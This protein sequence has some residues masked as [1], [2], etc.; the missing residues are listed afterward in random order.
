[1]RP[2][3]NLD[4]LL[5]VELRPRNMPGDVVPE[6][7]RKVRGSNNPLSYET[8]KVFLDHPSARVGIVTGVEFPPHLPHGEI[9][10]LIG[11]VVLGRALGKLG[12]ATS[13]LVEASIVPVIEALI[14]TLDA[15]R[16]YAVDVSPWST[17]D[18]EDCADASDIGVAIEKIG[19]NR[20]GIT[21]TIEGRAFNSIPAYADAYIDT[22]TAQGKLTVGYGDGGNEI[23]FGKM[24]DEARAIVPHGAVCQCACGDGIITQTATDV[25]WPVNVS[26]FGAYATAAA[27]AI[28]TEN[29]DLAITP[30]MLLDGL[31]AAVK[32]G[33]RDGGTGLAIPG[34]DGIPAATAAAFAQVIY[35]ALEH[36]LREVHRPF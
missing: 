11:A 20:K 14:E 8:A 6:L 28:L 17:K 21:H 32:A 27:L 29:P 33:A 1:M 7:Y 18:I 23:G 26:N 2:F 5:L 30:A 9:D 36:G 13:I 4:R 31:D 19:V 10:G 12:G 22:L 25:L 15:P 34:E 3:E 24:F 16:T 35:T